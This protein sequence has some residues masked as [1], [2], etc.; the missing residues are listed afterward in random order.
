MVLPPAVDFA[1]GFFCASGRAHVP[2]VPAAK[3]V[4]KKK[5]AKKKAAKSREEGR[6]EEE[7]GEEAVIFLLIKIEKKAPGSVFREPFF[8][9]QW[10]T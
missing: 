6:A 10:D 1:G 2:E 7:S 9:Q 4:G 8:T 5:V 3:A